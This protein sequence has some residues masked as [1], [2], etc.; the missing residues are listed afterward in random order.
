MLAFFES[1]KALLLLALEL[2]AIKI[3]PGILFLFS[4]DDIKVLYLTLRILNLLLE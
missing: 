2:E 3:D 1:D 4:F